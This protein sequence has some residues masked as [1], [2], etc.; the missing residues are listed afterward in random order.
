MDQLPDVCKSVDWPLRV[1]FSEFARFV[2]WCVATAFGNSSELRSLHLCFCCVL[3]R[4]VSTMCVCVCAPYS[5]VSLSWAQK[6]P[7]VFM[8]RWTT[9][10]I[11]IYVQLYSFDFIITAIHKETNIITVSTFKKKLGRPRNLWF[12]QIMTV[13]VS[14]MI[15]TAISVC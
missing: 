12:V 2:L 9:T 11:I 14:I 3:I 15:M 7:V 8:K 4:S 13:T 10:V 6:K 1:K 5:S